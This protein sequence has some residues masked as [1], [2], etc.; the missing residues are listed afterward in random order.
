MSLKQ[1]ITR[2]LRE[3]INPRLR[4]ARKLND[5]TIAAQIG[6]IAKIK[7]YFDRPG[8]KPSASAALLMLT[9]AAG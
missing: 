7:K 3:L 9:F 8:E 5:L 4:D 1:M 6:D 2:T